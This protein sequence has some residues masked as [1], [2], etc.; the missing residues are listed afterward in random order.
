MKLKEKKL[1][2]EINKALN[3]NFR[4]NTTND[5]SYLADKSY[6]WDDLNQLK[7]ELAHNIVEFMG[8]VQAIVANPDIIANLGDKK[9]HFEKV[10]NV[11]FVD[12]N[13]FSGKVKELREQHE[14][15]SGPVLDIN[16][17]S[18]YNRLAISYHAL[19]TE[20]QTLMTPTLSDIVLT[21]SSLVFPVQAQPAEAAQQPQ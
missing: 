9:E 7:A 2:T 10:V 17:F 15:M 8:Q 14:H 1:S 21:V 6:S 20:L 5:A 19:F 11:F 16:Q 4:I 13:S 18:V 3:D 12:L